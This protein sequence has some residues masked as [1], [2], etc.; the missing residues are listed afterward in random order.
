MTD[1]KD[2]IKKIAALRLRLDK[3]QGLLREV[4]T[5]AQALAEIPAETRLDQQLQKGAWHNSLID[6]ALRTLTDSSEGPLLPEKLIARGARLLKHTRDLLQALRTVADD[7]ALPQDFDA[8]LAVWHREAA[9]LVDNIL[10]TVQAFP[11]SPSSQLRLCHGLELVLQTAQQRLAAIRVGMDRRRVEKARIDRLAEIFNQ[12][13]ADPKATKDGLM[14][15]AEQ[16]LAEARQQR[17]LEY[18]LEQ[19]TQVSRY[20]AAHGYNVAQVMARLLVDDPTP[21]G[22]KVEAVAAALVHDVGMTAIPGEVLTDAGLFGPDQR[23][24]MEQ[25]C[26]HGCRWTAQFW[27]TDSL[28][29][30]AAADH[31]ERPDCLGYPAGKNAGQIDPLVRLL[32]ACDVYVALTSPRPYRSAHDPRTALTDTL[33]KADRGGLDR[34]EAEKLLRLGFYPVG[35]VVELDDGALARV[36]RGNPAQPAK[37]LVSL[38]TGPKRQPRLHGMV[39]DLSQDQHCQILRQA[40]EADLRKVEH[41]SWNCVI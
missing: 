23:R 29:A 25:H 7:P 35:C 41:G 27:T 6:G 37:P 33:L 3:A 32:A 11:S 38:L 26:H 39:V 30:Q 22:R 18:W 1:S 31:H 17:P 13:Q 36:S 10:R 9:A 20:A 12:S 2:I 24:L 5:A 4:G 34:Q 19:P 16:V 40:P 21:A 8:P 28:P 14:D 15:L